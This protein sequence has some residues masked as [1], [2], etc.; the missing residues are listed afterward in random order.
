MYSGKRSNESFEK[1]FRR[2]T[3][4]RRD[5]GF[6]ALM[7]RAPETLHRRPSGA[8]IPLESCC[9]RRPSVPALAQQGWGACSFLRAVNGAA[10][11]RGEGGSRRLRN[12][13]RCVLTASRKNGPP[14]PAAFPLAPQLPF[15]SNAGRRC[16]NP[17]L[18]K[19]QLSASRGPKFSNSRDGEPPYSPAG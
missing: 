16:A 15:Q 18:I 2:A 14:A 10:E 1:N 7:R 13:G 4:L 9:A 11:K 8:G 6:R 19:S 12:T 3:L 5:R 17:R